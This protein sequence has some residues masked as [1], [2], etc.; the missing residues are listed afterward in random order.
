MAPVSNIANFCQTRNCPFCSRPVSNYL[1]P[2]WVR[3]LRPNQEPR[4]PGRQRLS[5]IFT[6]RK[7]NSR[8]SFFDLKVGPTGMRKGIAHGHG[9]DLCRVRRR[10][11]SGGHFARGSTATELR[12]RLPAMPYHPSDRGPA[13]AG[14]FGRSVRFRFQCLGKSSG[15]TRCHEV[16]AARAISRANGRVHTALSTAGSCQAAVRIPPPDSASATP[17]GPS[18]EREFTQPCVFR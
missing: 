18:R 1:G 15:R 6:A 10:E 9:P 4:P 2:D 14:C 5:R 3:S 17:C 11:K 8:P 7:I 13:R 12:F 16:V